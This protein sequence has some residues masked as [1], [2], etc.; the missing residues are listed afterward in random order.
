MTQSPKLVAISVLTVLLYLGLAVAGFGG[1]AAFFAEP[2][3]V[4]LVAVR[5]SSPS[6]AAIR[7]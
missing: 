2:A 3:L 6:R 5:A 1:I 4:A 7:S